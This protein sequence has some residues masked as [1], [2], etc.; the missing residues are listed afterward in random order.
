MKISKLLVLFS[1]LSLLFTSCDNS[2]V[3]S[4]SND[5]STD[6]SS[7]NSEVL[8]SSIEESISYIE[9]PFVEV[10]L[11]DGYME[12]RKHIYEKNDIIRVYPHNCKA[13]DWVGIYA[14]ENEPGYG[15]SIIWDYVGNK[16]CV[17]FKVSS[18]KN[19]GEYSVFLCAND[20]YMVLDKDEIKVINDTTDYCINDATYQIENS[21]GVN[22]AS[23]TV[24]PSSTKELTYSFYWSYEGE[25][26]ENY[27]PLKVVT[28]KDKESFT[29]TLNESIFM[30]S[31]ATGIDVYVSEG[32]STSYFIEMDDTLKLKKSNYLYNFQ[33]LSDLHIE[34]GA[35]NHQSH[36]LTA[37]KEILQY[38]G[39]S[40]A[41]FTVGDNTN[42]GKDTDYILLQNTIGQIFKEDI[43][44]PQIYF[45]M[46][47][48]EYMYAS[49][50]E[51]AIASFKEYT[52]MP[53][54]YYSVDIKGSKF[55]VLGSNVKTLEGKIDTQQLEWLKNELSSVDKNKP[56]FIFV[57]QPLKDTVSGSIGS[58]GW[59]GM[60]GEASTIKELLK[61]YPNAVVFSGHTHWTLDSY[62]PALYG[63]KQNASYVNAASVGYLWNDADAR[64]P[65]SEG[66]FIEVYEDYI[67]VKGREF[68]DRK[69]VSA[70]QFVFELAK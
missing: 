38:A 46:G 16:E 35:A 25:R 27:T 57:H 22:Q 17:E 66:L 51:Q 11:T 8:S 70:A 1:T 59:D 29:V 40:E 43:T 45:S 67:L 19:I 47:N 4:S 60:R 42:R 30:P 63:K 41:V 44:H 58:Q 48:H 56:T 62:Q 23:I 15:T 34:E 65:G 7:V 31:E 50:Y 49:T 14:K 69:W 53:N 6:G 37:L 39:N 33:V 18:L 24:Y 21:N 12:M 55:I 26:L 28:V 52:G 20:G 13:K 61:D 64:E 3:E 5:V 10:P 68:V 54:I 9:N 36:L 32:L 2:N